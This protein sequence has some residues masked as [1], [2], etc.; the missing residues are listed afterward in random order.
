MSGSLLSDKVLLEL[1]SPRRIVAFT[2]YSAKSTWDGFRF[3]D[4]EQVAALKDV[5]AILSLKPD[6]VILNTHAA[7][8][9]I[10]RLRDE[11]LVVFNLGQMR[12]LETMTTD[13]QQIGALVG[14]DDR[15][16]RLLSRFQKRLRAVAAPK[17]SDGRSD[18]RSD[19]Q[20]GH[21]SQR[22]WQSA[23]RGAAHTSFHDVIENAGLIDIAAKTYSGW[24]RLSTVQ[25]LELDPDVIV[26]SEGKGT[27]L[28]GLA[29][30]ELLRACQN[31][32][33]G[34]IEGPSGLW[35][36]PGLGILDAAEFLHDRVF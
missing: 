33:A 2:T 34:I 22:L 23:V 24:P 17:R 26:V 35:A 31:G 7:D 1:V 18:E 8:A 16:A 20:N 5:E 10:Q 14:E 27:M 32:R 30:A 29:G 12:G 28:C 19:G 36:D 3:H 4:K 13:I 6:L 11:G 9:K 21:L 15:A 25:V